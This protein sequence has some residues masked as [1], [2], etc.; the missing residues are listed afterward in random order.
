[1]I[2]KN[3]IVQKKLSIEYMYNNKIIN[4]KRDKNLT[5]INK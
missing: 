1:M 2:K 5:H 4:Y 3:L